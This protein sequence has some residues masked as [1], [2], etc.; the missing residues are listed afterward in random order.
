MRVPN[1]EGG[2]R[3]VDH[4]SLI[5]LERM[6]EKSGIDPLCIHDKDFNWDQIETI[7]K[8]WTRRVGENLAYAILSSLSLLDFEKVV[9]EGAFPEK[10]KAL[11]VEEVET[12]LNSGDLQGCLLYTSPSPRDKRQSRMPSSA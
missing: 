5:I 7:T 10:V 1:Q 2:N 6:L 3:L 12:Q 8:E 4:A 9:I 11:I